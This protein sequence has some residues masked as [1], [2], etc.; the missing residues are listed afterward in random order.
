MSSSLDDTEAANVIGLGEL[1]GDDQH[2]DKVEECTVEDAVLGVVDIMR[3]R[4]E[5]HCCF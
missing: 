5:Y 3:P 2:V 1:V 4:W